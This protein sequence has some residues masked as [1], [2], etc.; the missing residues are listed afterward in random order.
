M[1][2][3]VVARELR[4]ERVLDVWAEPVMQ[5]RIPVWEECEGF[6]AGHVPVDGIDKTVSRRR[7][8]LVMASL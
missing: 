1:L 7:I 2:D 8:L 6:P 5:I 3:K 4:C